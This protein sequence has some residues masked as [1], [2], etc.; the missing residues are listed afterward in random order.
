LG[1][2]LVL[3]INPAALLAPEDHWMCSEIVRWSRKLG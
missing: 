2:L 1:W 3:A